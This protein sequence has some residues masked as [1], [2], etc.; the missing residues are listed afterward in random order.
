LITHDTVSHIMQ[1]QKDGNFV[2]SPSYLKSVYGNDVT[3]AVLD[4]K[5][6]DD[7]TLAVFE[8]DRIVNSKLPTLIFPFRP[9]I[10]PV[11]NVIT[12]DELEQ[13]KSML[14][15][16]VIAAKKKGYWTKPEYNELPILDGPCA[17][18]ICS[19]GHWKCGGCPP[20]RHPVKGNSYEDRETG[21]FIKYDGCPLDTVVKPSVVRLKGI[22]YPRP[23][24]GP[25]YGGEHS[26][27]LNLATTIYWNYLVM[28]DQDGKAT[29]D[30]YT[31]DLPGKF[32][33][34]IQGYA[35]TGL[36]SGKQEVTVVSK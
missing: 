28:T 36:I 3:L 32:T 10:L 19:C 16:V 5:D 20:L 35:E 30:F 4:N 18:W 2:L 23:F 7:F 31:N 21:M 9:F 24:Q 8:Q 11:N 12:P 15:K 6:K 25:D 33:C 14:V 1:T 34:I 29:F 13:D 27:N 17:A 22:Y 26:D